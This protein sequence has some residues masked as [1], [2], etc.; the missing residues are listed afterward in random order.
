MTQSIEG[1][2][3]VAGA[4]VSIRRYPA[5]ALF[6]KEKRQ[7]KREERKAVKDERKAVKEK[8]DE[9]IKPRPTFADRQEKAALRDKRVEENERV[10]KIVAE[11]LREIHTLQS[12]ENVVQLGSDL[13]YLGALS[14]IQLQIKDQLNDQKKVFTRWTVY[15]KHEQEFLGMAPTNR[16][17]EFGGITIS[18]LD[19]PTV[20]QELHYWDMVALLQQIQAP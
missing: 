5:R 3:S 6:N 8:L 14:G 19:G 16:D 7:E 15:G 2:P 1:Y 10:Q 17:V 11:R 18:F 20:T 12:T 13:L 9:V 4:T